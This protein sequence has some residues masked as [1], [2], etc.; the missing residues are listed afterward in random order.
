VALVVDNRAAIAGPGAHVLIV[1]VSDYLNL[2]DHDEPSLE[3]TWF[4]NK[5]TS[6][7]LSAFKTYEFIRHSALRLPLKTAR[8]LLSTSQ[9]ELGAEPALGTIGA[10]RATRLAFETFARDWR[11]DAK[12]NPGDM[13]IFYFA[14]H[15]IQRGPEDGVLLLEDFLAAGPPLAKCFEIGDI[16]NGMAP[17][18]TYPN[19][20][21]TQFYFVDA[22]LTRQE[23]QK[24][25]VNPQVPDVFG[26]ELNVVDR[27]EAPMM[28]STV[29]GA[30]ALGRAGKPSHFAEALTLA[31]QRAAEDPVDV[32]GST[33]WPITSLTIKT[34]LDSYYAKHNLGTKVKMGGVVGLPVIR[35]LPGAPDVDISIE[36]QP[37]SLGN[38]CGVWLY[39][40]N[41]KPVP[42]CDPTEKTQFETTVKAGIYRVQVESRLLKSSPYRSQRKF[43]TQRGPWPWLH[44]LATLLKPTL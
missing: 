34:A 16:R 21:L 9:V 19:V 25:F 3:S 39:D 29:D 31:L 40:D 10:T 43:V 41:D 7:A 26:V 15:G 36:V 37:D 18:P 6:A 23:T 30:I 2:P 42:Q 22:C 11:E 28:F 24:K 12:N 35:Y 13:T 8:L 17:S 14:G 5:L 20:A 38:P 4:L 44:N 33:V 27:R 1:G 32:N